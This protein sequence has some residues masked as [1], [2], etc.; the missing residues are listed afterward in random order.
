MIPLFEQGL[1]GWTPLKYVLTVFYHDLLSGHDLAHDE[2]KTRQAERLEQEH[3]D[4]SR[5]PRDGR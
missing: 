2:A 4:Q 3:G 1:P 5:L